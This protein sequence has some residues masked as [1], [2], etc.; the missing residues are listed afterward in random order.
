MDYESQ[1]EQARQRALRYGQQAQ[2]QNPQGQM[3][4]GRYIAPN[5][6]QYL[7]SALRAAGGMAGEQMET[8]QVNKLTKERQT[9]IA[10]ALRNFGQQAQGTPG[11]APG[12][13]MGPVLPAQAPD[14]MGAYQS[15][16]NAPDAGLRQ[17]GTQ[18]MTSLAQ[19]QAEAARKSQDQQRILGILQR[20]KTPQ[21]A[22]A[23]GVPIGV[24][25]DYY[26]SRNWG[27]DKVQW[28]DVGGQLIP[29][30]EYGET[31]QG[32][33]PVAKTGNPFSDLLVRDASGQLVP[34][35]PLVG[36]KTGLA[37]EGAAK[38]NVNVNMPDKKFYE[39][40]GTAVSGQIENAHGQAVAAAKTL[41]NANMIAASLGKAIVGPLANQR[42]TLA[43]IG[44]SLGVGGA[45]TREILQ[46]TRAVVQGLAR[47]ELAAAGQMKGQGQITESERAI[48]R[49]AESG[50]INEMT[51]PELETFIGAIRKTARGRI[52]AHEKN[53]QRLRRDPQSQ[54]IVDYLDVQAPSDTPIAPEKSQKPS[55][56][57]GGFRLVEE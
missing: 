22:L 57:A 24:A 20:S 3:V 11:N 16:L 13:G 52:A 44:Q 7:A 26:E 32:V 17:M 8:E 5:A 18:G 56:K 43:Q 45:D 21:E 14:M 48:L 30:T 25:K 33:A 2:Y 19:Q 47:Q 9:A 4:G 35:A 28:K 6:L 15:L 38:T 12:D 29:V 37:R 36:V 27:R 46:N 50:Q 10:D 54:T 42:V 40:L 51:R 23:A 39:G 55:I 49:K 34:N 31:P 1:I 41:E 53:M